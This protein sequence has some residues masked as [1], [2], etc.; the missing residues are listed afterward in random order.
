VTES[1]PKNRRRSQRAMLQL[2]VLVR[3]NM[4][5]GRCTQ[6]QAFTLV[7]NAH[8]GLLE[9]PLELAANQRITIINPQS[10]KDVVCRVLRIEGPSSG[11][12]QVAFEFDQPSAHFWPIAFPPDDWGV[13]EEVADDHR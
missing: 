2:A 4:P 8:G 10:C 13:V 1:D 7:V 3:A 12:F 5:D 9:S 6:V 11:L